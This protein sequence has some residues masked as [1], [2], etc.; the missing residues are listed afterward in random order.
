MSLMD[1]GGHPLTT[2]LY[3]LFET[4]RTCRSGRARHVCRRAIEITSVLRARFGDT[5]QHW[6]QIRDLIV[7][8]GLERIRPL[9][10]RNQPKTSDLGNKL[11]VLAD[12]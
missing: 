4:K 2:A 7:N 12:G 1:A 11:R 10:L 5:I 8:G 6:R 3:S 9:V